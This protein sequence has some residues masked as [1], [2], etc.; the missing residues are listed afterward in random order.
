MTIATNLIATYSNSIQG[1]TRTLIIDRQDD[2]THTLSGSWASSIN[3]VPATFPVAGSFLPAPG[4]NVNALLFV[5]S[6]LADVVTG[7]TPPMPATWRAFN[8]V[9]GYAEIQNPG[10]VDRLYITIAWA[11]DNPGYAKST[12]AWTP[13]FLIRQ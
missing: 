12:S 1:M 10:Q 6:G 7:Q 8:A 2:T 4:G 13:T 11:E 3:G 9:I 5:L